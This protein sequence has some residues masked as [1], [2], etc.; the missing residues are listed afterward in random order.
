ML[1]VLDTNVLVSALRSRRGASFQVITHI[2]T[3][4]F[5]L[6]ISVPLVVEYEA[7][8]VRHLAHTNLSQSDISAIVDYIC[9]V[10]KWQPIF[11][12]WRP[13]LSDPKDD[14]I[15][16][17]AIAAGCDA[18][19]THNIADFDELAKLGVRVLRPAELLSEIT[20]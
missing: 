18:V 16:E 13:L 11:F 10:A 17:L 4:A 2:G 15:A 5:R 19:V 8:M 20:R 14:M 7:A 6:A 12:L 9:S 1:I 3:E